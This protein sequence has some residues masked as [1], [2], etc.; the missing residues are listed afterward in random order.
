MWGVVEGLVGWV[1]LDG[2]G[3]GR[4]IAPAEAKSRQGVRYNKLRQLLTNFEVVT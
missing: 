3:G 2:V 4:N 1:G